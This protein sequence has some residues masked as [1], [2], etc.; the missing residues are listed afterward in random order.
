[1]NR[2]NFLRYA[3]VGAITTLGITLA[4]Q[5][6]A[7][8]Q[9]GT[10]N[11][12]WLGHTCFLFTGSGG[13]ILVNP[14]DNKGCARNYRSLSSYGNLGSDYVFISSRLADEGSF[15]NLPGSAKLLSQPGTYD[16]PQSAPR[17]RVQGIKTLHDRFGGRRF[18][19]NIAWKW[20]QNGINILHMGG[21]AS[22]LGEEQLILMGQTDLM[23]IPVGGGD[24]A[25]TA[26]E[27]KTAI[28]LIKPK[29][30]VP[31]HY[32]TA[33]SDPNACDLTGVED[34]LS[35]MS[36]YPIIQTGRQSLNFS[37]ASLPTSGPQIQVMSYA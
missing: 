18:G 24:K 26:Q 30:V 8:G 4:P 27:A 37:I 19:D 29:V 2:R 13:R 23:F 5:L 36:G 9:S 10:L 35:I 14:F 32:R 31:M 12:R 1:M 22:I 34:F 11:V 25:Y 15:Q 17:L 28:D 6:S 33:Q 3:Q 21:I 7:R 20:Q 16:L